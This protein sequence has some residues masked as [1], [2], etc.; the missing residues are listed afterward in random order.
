YRLAGIREGVVGG[1]KELVESRKRA[2]DLFRQIVSFGRCLCD[3]NERDDDGKQQKSAPG[4][5]RG[6][7]SSRLG[8]GRGCN[9][10]RSRGEPC[11]A[12]TGHDGESGGNGDQ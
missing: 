8:K 10:G 12:L 2:V 5:S 1:V 3:E 11:L 7:K 9:E 4:N 6:C